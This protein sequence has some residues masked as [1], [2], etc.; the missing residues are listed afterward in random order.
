M[1]IKHSEKTLATTDLG[2]AAALRVFGI[3]M[4]RLDAQDDRRIAFIFTDDEAI[5][6]AARYWAGQLSVD[7]LA[8]F[9]ALKT[10]KNQIYSLR[11]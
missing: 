11:V 8:Y 3:P 5:E 9:N 6:A 10:L 7:A 4:L 2:L 1:T